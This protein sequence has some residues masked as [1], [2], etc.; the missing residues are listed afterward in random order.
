MEGHKPRDIMSPLQISSQLEKMRAEKMLG[1]VQAY[2]LL[3]LE[4]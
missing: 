1:F 2:L 3:T 4:K